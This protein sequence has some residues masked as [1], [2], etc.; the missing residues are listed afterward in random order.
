[1][2]P[3][4]ALIAVLFLANCG[5]DGAPIKPSGSIG[6]GIGSNGKVS[7]GAN[8]GVKKGNVSV[9]VSL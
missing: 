4:A 9:G 7:T 1:M 2:K 6:I 8:V 3:L 5:V